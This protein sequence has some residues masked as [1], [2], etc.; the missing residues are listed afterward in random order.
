[1]VDVV[2]TDN[3]QFHLSGSDVKAELIG[4]SVVVKRGDEVFFISNINNIKSLVRVEDE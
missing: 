3:K 2:T 4:V 1:M